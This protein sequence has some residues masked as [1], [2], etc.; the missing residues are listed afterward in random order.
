MSMPHKM[1]KEMQVK[2]EKSQEDEKEQEKWKEFV[3][4]LDFGE[5]PST[6]H[7]TIK[8]LAGKVPT[9]RTLPVLYDG[10]RV[11][12]DGRAKADLLAAHYASVSCPLSDLF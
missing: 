7:N 9:T 1:I 8:S 12:T 3:S 11:L 10:D 5:N 6:V 4:E 2:Q